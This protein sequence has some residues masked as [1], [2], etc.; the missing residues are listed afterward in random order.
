MEGQPA[1]LKCKAN[2]D[3]EPEVHWI[4]PEGRLISNG[5][6]YKHGEQQNAPVLSVSIDF[7]GGQVLFEQYDLPTKSTT[8]NSV[9]LAHR[10][11]KRHCLN[12]LPRS[13]SFVHVTVGL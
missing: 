4:S 13:S 11:K 5:S 2:G 10:Q 8:S 7:I 1:S 12:S 6:R 3:P 9:M